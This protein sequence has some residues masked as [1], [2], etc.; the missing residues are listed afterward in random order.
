MDYDITVEEFTEAGNLTPYDPISWTG[1]ADAEEGLA[2]LGWVL[3]W[4]MEERA[5]PPE[6]A[7]SMNIYANVE[8]G[9]TL[10]DLMLLGVNNWILCRSKFAFM[11]LVRDWLD[12]LIN[13]GCNDERLDAFL[14]E[15]TDALDAIAD[16]LG[17]LAPALDGATKP[18]LRQHLTT[19]RK[20]A[21]SGVTSES[22]IE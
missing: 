6:K 15:T 17:R 11:K 3:T 12:P 14:S 10:V 7:V 4:R 2:G 19:P 20:T 13:L 16:G 22:S 21:S 9:C 5:E 1:S 8:T 18:G